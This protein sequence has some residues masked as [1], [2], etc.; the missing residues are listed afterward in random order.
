MSSPLAV[1]F[2]Y[3]VAS[4]GVLSHPRSGGLSEPITTGT[5]LPSQRL[6]S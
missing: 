2:G 3:P 4:S 6:S 1:P 5:F